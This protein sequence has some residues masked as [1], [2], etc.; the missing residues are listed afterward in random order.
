[1][2]FHEAIKMRTEFYIENLKEKIFRET[3]CI[4]LRKYGEKWAWVIIVKRV[5]NLDL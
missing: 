5:I 2:M 4:I 3:D 1:M